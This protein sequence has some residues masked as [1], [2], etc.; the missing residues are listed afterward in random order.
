M[1]N[2]K[3]KKKSKSKRIA[4]T[5]DVKSLSET[6]AANEYEERHKGHFV[7]LLDIW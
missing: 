1:R 5:L 4:N 2:C 6:I 7:F 3:K